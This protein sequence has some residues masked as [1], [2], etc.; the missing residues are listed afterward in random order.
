MTDLRQMYR[1]DSASA[2]SQG[3]RDYQEDAYIA[4]FPRGSDIGLAVLADGMGGHAAGDVASQIVV[5]EVLSELMF[6]RK[7]YEHNKSAL[8]VILRQ[9][10][11]C[12][13][14]SIQGYTAAHPRAHGM[15]ATLVAC[16][17]IDD[18]LH[19]ISVGDS[20]LY[21]FR[22]NTLRQINEDHSLGP[23]IE[24]MV[25]AGVL[26]EQ[27]GRTHPDRSV[28]TSVL[29]GE[30]IPQ[31]DCPEDPL[32]LL[33]G[34]TIII[35]SDGLQYLTDDAIAQVLRERPFAHCVDVVDALMAAVHNLRDPD[36]DNVTIGMLRV[37]YARSDHV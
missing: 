31:I 29:M 18:A 5:T 22:N 4:D 8:P 35:G 21:L 15:G 30:D 6:R 37:Q 1:F 11:D 13:N 25:A 20:P 16:V 26:S 34:D 2:T 12:A 33:P 10:A 9:A 28:L 27:E 19:W 7:T 17:V 14:A 36:L 23:M 3:G 24:E 32:N